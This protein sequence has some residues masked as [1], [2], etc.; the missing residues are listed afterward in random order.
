MTRKHTSIASGQRETKRQPS[1]GSTAAEA[2]PLRI[3]MRFGSRAVPGS[4]TAE[5]SSCVYGCSGA[6]EHLLDRAVLDDL[7]RVHDEDVVGDVPRAREV[8]GDVEERYA[9]LLFELQHQVEDPDANRHVEHARRL[10][11]EQHGR[12]DGQGARD[13]DALALAA[14]ELMRILRR[15]VLGRHEAD[16]LE[17]VVD[18]RL[19][20]V[21]RDDPV[22]AK[23]TLEVMTDRLR[24][25]QGAER[26]LK[27]HLHL[28]AVVE[29]R[30]AAAIARDVAVAEA[31]RPLA[32]RV[33]AREQ[34]GNR[35][36]P[37]PAL[38]DERGD[39]AAAQHEADLVDRVHG[40]PS[41]E[42]AAAGGEALR[43]VAHLE[44]GVT[45]QNAHASTS[46][47]WQ[48]TRCS[49][50]TSRSSG[51]SVVCRR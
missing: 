10:V 46:A 28:R 43:E 20:L 2:R 1:G 49:G 5:S 38:A 17:Q 26:I 11:R 39:R 7:A 23:R 22:D 45:F 33:Q 27:D 12:L 32:R 21:R 30:P 42:E 47:R 19:D 40:A 3:S 48:A 44:R 35:A 25:V 16:V 51:R 4:G 13:R 18:V 37:A 8:V 31:D 24:R 41:A 9:A 6:R 34:A 14:G 50:S 15:D 29:D 36:L